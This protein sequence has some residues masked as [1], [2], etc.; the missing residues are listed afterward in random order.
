MLGKQAPQSLALG[1]LGSLFIDDTNAHTGQWGRIYCI[2]ACGFT[3]LTSGNLPDG[4]KCMTGSALT[5]ITLSPGM[6]LQG[7]FTAI[8]LS[9]GKVVA[10]NI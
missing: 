2:A 3:T 6:E 7:I 8:T 10:Y 4:T 9:S 1:Q 5:G